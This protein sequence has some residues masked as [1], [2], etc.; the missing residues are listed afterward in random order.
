MRRTNIPMRYTND[1][2]PFVFILGEE[3]LYL[4]PMAMCKTIIFAE[5][6][7]TRCHNMHPV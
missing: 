3:K 4:P 5:V 7:L 6:L 2:I 1:A